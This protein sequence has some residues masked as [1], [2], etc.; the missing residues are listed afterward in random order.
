MSNDDSQQPAT[1][2]IDCKQ[3]GGKME[4]TVLARE[5]QGM[6]V[7][8]LI[9][10]LIGIG[11]LFIFPIGTMIGIGLLIAAPR[12]ANTSKRVWKCKSCGYFFERG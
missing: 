5:H 9:V 7:L 4:K 6:L 3:C 11:L 8:A 2:E 1:T 10:A 12:I